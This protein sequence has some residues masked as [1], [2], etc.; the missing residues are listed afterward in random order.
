MAIKS[1]KLNFS[2]LTKSLEEAKNG[3]SFDEYV[4]SLLE[5]VPEKNKAAAAKSFNNLLRIMQAQRP[6]D[7]KDMDIKEVIDCFTYRELFNKLFSSEK[8]GDVMDKIIRNFS[9]ASSARKRRLL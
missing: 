1:C 4:L 7:L 6:E 3:P 9:K 5:D 2:V 8:A